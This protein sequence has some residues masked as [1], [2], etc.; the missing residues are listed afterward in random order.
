ML[1]WQIEA[2]VLASLEEKIGSACVH[3]VEVT[4][5]SV[6]WQ[7]SWSLYVLSFEELRGNWSVVQK[8]GTNRLRYNIEAATKIV[9]VSCIS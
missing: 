4:C 3:A 1:D 6:R 8:R 9:I 2:Q 5:T 7:L